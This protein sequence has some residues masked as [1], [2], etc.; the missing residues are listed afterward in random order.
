L[1]TP[2]PA[3]FTGQQKFITSFSVVMS[4]QGSKRKAVSESSDDEES[5]VA[6]SSASD[7]DESSDVDE[8]SESPPPKKKRQPKK[9]ATKGKGKGGK[10]TKKKKDPNAPKKAMT[11]YMAYQQ[12]VRAQVKADNPEM[13]FGDL[14]RKVAADWKALTEKQKEKY[15]EI[16]DKDKER[17]KKAMKHYVPP[18]SSSSDSDS[19]AKKPKKK[20]AKR[21]PNAPKKAKNAFLFY[22]EANRADVAASNPNAKQAELLKILGAKWK[23]LSDDEKKPYN[24]KVE[25]DKA[26]YERE[27]KVYNKGS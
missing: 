23:S 1:K 9:G 19:D 5:S 12:A 10:K 21:D 7:S 11:A 4:R 14:S 16:S 25:E 3:L 20:K 26:R 6:S 27:I 17:Y 15:T 2:L 18:S 8:S 24:K 13:K 22:V